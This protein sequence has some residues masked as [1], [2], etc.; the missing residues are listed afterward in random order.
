[1]RRIHSTALLAAASLSLAPSASAQRGATPAPTVS[2]PTVARPSVLVLPIL[3]DMHDS[4]RTILQ[5]DLD[6]GDALEVLQVE[7]DLLRPLVSGDDPPVLHPDSVAQLGARFVVRAE[8]LLDTLRVTVYD[9]AAG[10]T[11]ATRDFVVTSSPPDR[12][13]FVHDSLVQFYADRERAARERLTALTVRY[14]SLLRASRGRQPRNLAQREIEVAR[15]DSM[16]TAIAAEGTRLHAGIARL[17]VERDSLLRVRVP[18][19]QAEFDSLSYIERMMLHAAADDLQHWLTGIRGAAASRIAFLRGSLL[20]VVDA[21]GTHERQLTVRGRA[22]SP[23]WH[24]SGRWIVYSDITDV[25]TQIAEVDVGTGKVRLLTV[26]PRGYNITPVYTPDGK[27]IVFAAS[28]TG[29]SQLVS[30]DRESSRLTRLGAQTRNA[31][32]PTFSP[33][34]RR[35]A[36]VAPRTWQGTGSTVRMTP[37]LFTATATGTGLQQLT[38]STFGVRSYRTSPEWSPDGRY[39]TYTQQGGGFQVWLIGVNDKRSRQLTRGRDHEDASWAPDSR[40]L[41]ITAGRDQTDLIVLDIVTGR[42][43]ELVVD[44]RLPAW[45]PRWDPSHPL[46]R[47]VS[48]YATNE[49]E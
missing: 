8:R 44:G 38:A 11:P 19:A 36:F 16:F 5:R 13:R 48:T 7:T 24:P 22:L 37:Q 26:T 9:T 34:G 4:I 43:R 32:S 42:S 49:D 20:Y 46:V 17:P 27:R 6:Y 21:D 33:N 14:D 15:R 31:S 30:V 2:Q 12:A 10:G 28:G 18:H 3:R 45:S 47:R 25:G 39:V 23:A 40:H 41:V 29:G 1:M 35:M